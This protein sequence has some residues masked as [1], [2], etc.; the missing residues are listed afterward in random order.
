MPH[1][2]RIVVDLP[3]PLGPRNPQMA[4]VGISNE[5]WSTATNESKRRVRPSARTAAASGVPMPVAGRGRGRG[6]AGL[7]AFLDHR[8]E[9]VLE[10]RRDALGPAHGGARPLEF[11]AQDWDR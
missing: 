9:H 2:I 3:A 8:D 11:R 5:T 1:S 4:P 6:G 10:R 7:A